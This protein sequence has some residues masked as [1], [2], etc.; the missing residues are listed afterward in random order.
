MSDLSA[1]ERIRRRGALLSAVRD[2]LRGG[3][4]MEVETPVRVR[5]PCP[6]EHIDAVRCEGG[7]LR[8]SP[9]LHMKRMLCAGAERIYAAGPCFRRGEHGR[10]HREEYTML[11]WYRVGAGCRDMIGETRRLVEACAGA[12]GVPA[13]RPWSEW[14]V[15]EAFRRHAGWDPVAAFEP[16]R[17]DFDLTDRV[18]PAIKKHGGAVLLY[19]YPAG[20][21]ALARLDP[22]PPRVAERWELYIEGLEI[23]NAYSELTDP[24]E[25]RGRFEACNADRAR[26]GRDVYPVDEAFLEAMEA[27]LPECAGIAL[28]ID[29]LLM[30][31]TGAQR[32]DDVL[33][34]PEGQGRGCG[35]KSVQD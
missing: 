7:W 5:A 1:H 15:A 4:Y 35:M 18:E 31:L 20:R 30:A 2:F 13:P 8:T 3:G 27:G 9:E 16:D 24:V 33:P 12:L 25:Q 6:E 32:I 22:G 21:A 17:F 28:G 14:S 19:G 11:E 10:L 23:A 26:R 34:F 29:R